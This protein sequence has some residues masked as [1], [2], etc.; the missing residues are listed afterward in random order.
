MEYEVP[1]YSKQFHRFHVSASGGTQNIDEGILK[2]YLRREYKMGFPMSSRPRA[3]QIVQQIVDMHLGLHEYS[4]IRGKQEEISLP[5]AIRHGMTEYMMYQPLDWDNGADAEAFAEFKE[6]IAEMAQHAAKGV[7]EFFGDEEIVGEYQRWHKDERIDV[8]CMMFLDY[9]GPTRQID[10]KCS[11]PLKNPLKKD[12]T[13]TWRVPKPKETPTPQQV[14]QQAVYW[15]AT[16][17]EPA[18]LFVTSAGY[19]ICTPDNCP[20]LKEPS[21]ERA[22]EDVVR[23]WL[24]MQNLMKAANG[25]WSDLFSLVPPDFGMIATRHGPEVFKIAQNAWRVQ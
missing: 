18:L 16:G 10:L 21:L 4:P 6:H 25:S 17:L 9:A 20:A 8:P 12:G 3:G 22:Y 13:R 23:R 14:M 1:E 7:K 24:A 15:K 19:N 11:L 5:E 2:L